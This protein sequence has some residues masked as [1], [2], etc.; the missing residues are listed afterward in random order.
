MKPM[1]NT[2]IALMIMGGAV[3]LWCGCGQ[4]NPEENTP[5]TTAPAG[6]SKMPGNAATNE[7]VVPP[8]AAPAMTNS[9]NTNSPNQK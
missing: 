1:K 5:S 3:A 7:V 6:N 4:G 2:I 9:D 8:A